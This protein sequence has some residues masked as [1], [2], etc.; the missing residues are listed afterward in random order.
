[1]FLRLHILQKTIKIEAETHK[2][3]IYNASGK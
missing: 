2:E 3:I 1:M